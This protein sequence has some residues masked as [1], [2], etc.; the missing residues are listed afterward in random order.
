MS[1]FPV[2]ALSKHGQS[3]EDLMIP[4]MEN[5][6]HEPPMEYMEFYED[7]DCEVDE[8]TGRRGYWQNPNARWDWLEIGGRF[9]GRLRARKGD[10]GS[11][12]C[13]AE[14]RYDIAEMRDVSTA[15][16]Q[17]EY[18]LARGE[19]NRHL[20]GE[21][22]GRYELDCYKPEYV[23]SKFQDAEF[24]ARWRADFWFRAVVTPDGEWHEVGRM[25]WWGISDEDGDQLR[26]W[27]D[28]FHERFVKPY[29]DCTATVIDCH[30]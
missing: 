8:R 28:H 1:H 17:N 26:D 19:F 14:G 12:G 21:E 23:L 13:V 9:S 22:V 30:I 27:L 2:L 3:V 6:C 29:L 18:R 7:D 11:R 24:Y 10:Y 25:L 5:C 15:R 4:Y 20:A 16:D